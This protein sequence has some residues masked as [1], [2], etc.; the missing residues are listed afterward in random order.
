MLTDTSAH[1]GTHECP[2]DWTPRDLTAVVRRVPTHPT[3]LPLN[4]PPAHTSN[5]VRTVNQRKTYR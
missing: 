2:S 3:P 5:F 1:P 4:P